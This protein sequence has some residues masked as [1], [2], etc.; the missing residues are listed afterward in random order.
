MAYLGLVGCL[1]LSGNHE[2]EA[3]SPSPSSP[4]KRKQPI[5]PVLPT[6]RIHSSPIPRKGKGK[7]VEKVASR[8]E[9][10]KQRKVDKHGPQFQFDTS[11]FQS[12]RKIGVAV[13]QRQ[14]ADGFML[15]ILVAYTRPDPLHRR[16]WTE[17]RMDRA[18][19]VGSVFPPGISAD[20][21]RTKRISPTPSSFSSPVSSPN[22]SVSP[23]FQSQRPFPSRPHLQSRQASHYPPIGYQ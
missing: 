21:P 10:R 2:M 12:G 1:F 7:A 4:L 19:G 13:R 16:G 20:S 15:M 5:L 9:K 22:T 3:M 8:E 6:T 14:S 23:Q 11:H 18:R 17:T